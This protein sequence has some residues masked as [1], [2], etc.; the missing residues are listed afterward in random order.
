MNSLQTVKSGLPATPQEL[1]PFIAVGTAAVNAAKKVLKSNRLTKEQFESVLIKGQE[2]AGLVFDAKAEIGKLIANA[3]NGKGNNQHCSSK[4]QSKTTIYTDLN[5]SRKQADNYQLIANNPEA[6]EKAKAIAREN[7]D[8]PTESLVLQI[9]RQD[10]ISAKRDEVKTL[11]PKKINGKYDVIYADP[12]WQYEFSETEN[13]AI[14]N[15]YPTMELEEIKNMNIPAED[16]AILLMW[17][18]APKLEEAISVLNAWGFS[19]KTCAVWDKE[20][21][22][23]GYWFR[24][25]HELLLV[26]T[27][28]KFSAPL[29]EN[30]VSSV[31]RET[32]TAHSKKPDFY[33]GLIEKM[34]PDGKYLELFARQKFNKKWEVWGNQIE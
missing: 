17:A 7:N 33:Y 15:K 2:Q 18:T 9:A 31:Y 26:G 11:I 12:P 6:V 5:L 24:G 3:P 23:M 10:K 22:G 16:S 14:E 21:I 20:K 27:K 29:P 1:V 13:R 34:F 30:R 4:E 8:I 19:Y 28:G 32:R 25:Q